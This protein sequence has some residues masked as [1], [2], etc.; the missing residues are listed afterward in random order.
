VGVSPGH[1]VRIRASLEAGVSKTT[2]S[3]E[4]TA[5]ERVLEQ[6]WT[7]ARAAEAAGVSVRTVSKWLR[8]YRAAGAEGLLDRL[9]APGWVPRRIP[10]SALP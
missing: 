2:Q 10:E 4:D 6:G 1:V 3:K 8:R 9:S 7:L 5:V